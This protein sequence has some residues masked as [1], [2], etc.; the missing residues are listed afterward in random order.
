VRQAAKV[1]LV[2][3][4]ALVFP[5]T[6][7]A[8]GIGG[9][10]DIPVPLWLFYYG[11]A[12]VLIVSFIALGVLWRRPLLEAH[13][14]GRRLPVQLERV[15]L[16][17]A[18]RVVLGAASFV[19]LAVVTAAALVGD[20]AVN[21]NLAP[22]FVYIA[23]WLGLVPIVV[24]F[25]NVWSVLSP[26]RAGADA[27]VWVARR[28]GREPRP[29]TEYPDR[30]GRWPAAV[31]LFLWAVLELAYFE[32]ANPRVVGLAILF[33]SALTWYGTA[34]FGRRAWLERGEA[35]N[36]YFGLLGRL[37][38]F[39][40]RKRDGEREAVVRPPLT[41][42]SLRDPVPGTLAFVAVMLGSVTFDGFSRTDFWQNRRFDLTS[43]YVETSP[44]LADIVWTL[45]NLAGL[46]LVI[47]LVALAF[48][49]A[50]RAAQMLA[51]RTLEA[52]DFVLSLVPIALAYAV[53]HY[54]SAL[55]Q[56]GQYLIPLISDPFGYGW[57]I[58]GTADYLARFQLVSPNVTWYVQVSALVVGHVLGL[59][60]A[61][62]RAVALFR[63]GRTALNTQ[64]AMLA[65]MI[66]Y[67]VTGL[68]LLWQ[69]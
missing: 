53:A 9:I 38:P 6:A 66:A 34:V 55:I 46:V 11:A 51:S 29:L 4:A 52:S 2:A 14:D 13:A 44:T 63:S 50:L 27:Y 68:W 37:A 40:V 21:E 19:L 36:V 60:L 26:W 7:A 67:T 61:H 54:F 42:L 56:E 35:F 69:D 59:T 33:Y 39:A 22:R 64:Y 41:G 20:G 25:G 48:L 57:D 45:F 58:F 24:L 28:L 3:I 49:A 47:A 30:W 43:G 23:F 17:R 16:S 18:L 5:A 62:D 1:A 8:H 15:I 32:P 65:L 10:R 12:I 31:F